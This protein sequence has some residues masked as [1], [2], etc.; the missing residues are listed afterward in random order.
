M[1]GRVK[2]AI[3]GLG[4]IG[5]FHALHAQELA[6]DE[7]SCE[8]V[9]VVDLDRE[10]AQHLAK[11]MSALQTKPVQAF[12][13]VDEL[14]SS[15]ASEAAVICSPTANHREHAEA[16][17]KA[18][19]PVLLEKPL[20]GSLTD[21]R[22][23]AAFLKQNHPHALMLAFQRRFDAALVHAKRLLDNGH[24]GRPFKIVSVLEDS[25]PLP[26]GYNSPG[27]LPDMSVHNVDEVL[28]LSGAKPTAVAGFGMRLH[29]CALA[30]VEEDYDDALLGMWFDDDLA[31]QVHVSRNHVSGYRTE[32][33]IFGDEG[34]IHIGL[35]QQ[36]FDSIAVE[37]YGETRVI[38]RRV[39][40][41]RNY[42]RPVPEFID[43]FGLA[44]KAELADFI[45]QLG[46]GKPF[47]VNQEDGLRAMEVIEAGMRSLRG[48]E[49][50][51][52]VEY[53]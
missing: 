42:G 20:T 31:A 11:R 52:A 15:G 37:A 53:S 40:P 32:T 48:R 7:G 45:E 46:Q 47:C 26:D 12:A 9:A 16:L 13:T 24:I 39:F 4:R 33:W 8:L 6:R 41:L 14:L 51:V 38:E 19:Q 5:E 49:D 10:K 34:Q 18:N 17:I 22:E 29:S 36:D 3:I 50:G 25:G 30:S 27:L 1:S 35:F 2:L 28:W 43:R 21:G 44:Y 23:F